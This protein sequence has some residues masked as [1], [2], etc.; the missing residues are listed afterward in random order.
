MIRQA[1]FDKR[2]AL[3][4]IIILSCIAID[5]LDDI[6]YYRNILA[7]REGV[8]KAHFKQLMREAVR[9]YNEVNERIHELNESLLR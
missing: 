4:Q 3:K 1:H 8:N 5:K 7:V 9:E 2:S 6:I